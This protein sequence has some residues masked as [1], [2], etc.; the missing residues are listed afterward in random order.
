MDKTNRFPLT[1][2]MEMRVIKKSESLLC[3]ASIGK[4]EHVAYIEVLSAADTPGYEEYFREI[5]HEWKKLGGIPHWQKQWAFLDDKFCDGKKVGIF[6][7]IQDMYGD[8][9]TKFNDVRK[10]YD[11]SCVFMNKTMERLFCN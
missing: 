6:K 3:P 9:L 11:P 4:E 1:L 2:C 5:A 7:H 10:K 8:N